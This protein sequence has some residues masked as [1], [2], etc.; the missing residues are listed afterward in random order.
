MDNFFDYCG[1]K[2]NNMI[3]AISA[4]SVNLAKM[5]NQTLKSMILSIGNLSA[6]LVKMINQY[7]EDICHANYISKKAIHLST[8]A[9]K[10][11]TRKKNLHRVQKALKEC[12]NK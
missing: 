10:I 3:T 8:N 11:R 5:T 7:L 1:E 6:N 9:K 4:L 2:T 12:K